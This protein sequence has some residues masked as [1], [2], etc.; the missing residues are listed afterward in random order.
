MRGMLPDLGPT[1]PNSYTYLH[2][3]LWAARPADI[4]SPQTH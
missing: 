4:I 1:V 3:V 2:L